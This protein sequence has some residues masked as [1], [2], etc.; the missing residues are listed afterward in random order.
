MSQETLESAISTMLK[1]G[2]DYY[3][4]QPTL[5]DQFAMAALPTLLSEFLV[6]DSVAEIAARSYELADAMTEARNK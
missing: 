6:C 1:T 3:S 5:R 4:E 2:N